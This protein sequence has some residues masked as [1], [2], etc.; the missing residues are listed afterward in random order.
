M[1]EEMRKFMN[2]ADEYGKTLRIL[3]AIS[4]FGPGFRS[5]GTLISHS[6]DGRPDQYYVPVDAEI[7]DDLLIRCEGLPEQELLELLIEKGILVKLSG[8]LTQINYDHF[9]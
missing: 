1:S 8:R 4:Q 6:G 2:I 5:E 9:L 3:V 7:S